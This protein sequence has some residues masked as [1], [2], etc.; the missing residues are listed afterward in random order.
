MTG[1]RLLRGIVRALFLV[2]LP[3]ALLTTTVRFAFSEEH[4]YQY[5][6]DYYDVPSVTHISH[7]DLIAATEDIRAYFQ[8]SDDYLRTQV[9]D[10]SG[11]LV[12]LF[13]SKEVLHMHDVKSLVRKVYG[14]ETIAICLVAAYV[15]GVFLWAREEGIEA[16]ARRTLL[17]CLVTVGLIVAF[18]V[19]AATGSFDALFIRFHELSFGNNFWQLDPARDHL[20]QMFPEG[21]WQD[22][23]LLIAGL[24]VLEALLIGGVSFLYLRHRPAASPI[25][26]TEP[27]ADASEP[28][29]QLPL[30]SSGER[31]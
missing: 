14:L 4:V 28:S 13:N 26:A 31:T 23:T 9:H 27:A 21:F 12:P 3:L 24:T 15:A 7:A 18:G 22:A 2:A 29:E 10:Q 17:T 8:N 5:S 6:I 30:V 11:S 19:V 25:P 1:G 16:L 20:V